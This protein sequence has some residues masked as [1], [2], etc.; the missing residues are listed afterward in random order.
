MPESSSRDRAGDLAPFLRV[1]EAARVLSVS[2]RTV[3]RLI[4]S[5]RLVAVR[6]GMGPRAH[7]RIPADA[8]DRLVADAR[9]DVGSA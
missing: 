9:A 8:L 7:L 5:R 6:T 3:R 1:L 4:E 2:P